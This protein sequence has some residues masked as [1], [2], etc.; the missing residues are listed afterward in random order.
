[1]AN[2][3]KKKEQCLNIFA[4]NSYIMTSETVSLPGKLGTAIVNEWL[5]I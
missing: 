4:H 3:I 1:M 2:G 5:G